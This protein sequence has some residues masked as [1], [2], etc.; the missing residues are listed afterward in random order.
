VLQ[1]FDPGTS[2]QTVER[3]ESLWKDKLRARLVG[4][5]RN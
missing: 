3:V 4:Y 5:N 2:D 1:T